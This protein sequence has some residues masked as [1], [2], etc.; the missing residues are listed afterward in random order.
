MDKILAGI[1]LG[2][3]L[4]YDAI[5]F[6][7]LYY[8][9]FLSSPI[10]FLILTF[11][12]CIP[13]V[14]KIPLRIFCLFLRIEFWLIL[15]FSYYCYLSAYVLSP[16]SKIGFDIL[17]QIVT[18]GIFPGLL[19]AIMFSGCQNINWNLILSLGLSYCFVVL[20]YSE[21]Y[22]YLR[23]S[24]PTLNPIWCAKTSLAIALIS[25]FAKRSYPCLRVTSFFTGIYVAIFTQSRGPFISFLFLILLYLGIGVLK[26]PFF[27]VK[28]HQIILFLLIII[29]LLFM[30][31]LRIN[32]DGGEFLI[33]RFNVFFDSEELASDL[34]YTSRLI[35]FSSA[36]N[37]FLMNPFL[38][39]GLGF[40]GDFYPH[41]LCLDISA[42]LG[43]LGFLFFGFGLIY[44]IYNL[45]FILS[46]LIIFYFLASMFSGDMRSS[47][48]L[49]SIM[50]LGLF[51]KPISYRGKK[52]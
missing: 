45:N 12:V 48:E 51:W 22:F 28:L 4:F 20:I 14:S 32:S 7:A 39:G 33:S 46:K 6:I 24:L 47:R 38:G 52:Y 27:R 35:Y 8:F 42:Q 31:V 21:Q 10:L 16:N 5:K 3:I 36:L 41:N 18:E 25:I 37:Y 26:C 17:I 19:L 30:I 9:P 23:Y 29:M 15:I 13:I 1:F 50:I 44:S 40:F 34:N 2:I 49:F 11:L 43:L